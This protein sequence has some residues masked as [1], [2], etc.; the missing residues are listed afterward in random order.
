PA[1]PPPSSSPVTFTTQPT[2][3][4]VQTIILWDSA[5][6]IHTYAEY[7]SYDLPGELSVL[8]S[9][10]SVHGKVVDLNDYD[11]ITPPYAQW[12]AT[13]APL[14]NALAANNV[15]ADIRALLYSFKPAYPNLKYLVLVG[16][17]HIIPFRRVDDLNPFANEA[18]YPT[19]ARV[20]DPATR[21]A[22]GSQ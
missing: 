1:V 20:P 16:S 3:P 7:F 13:T 12:D 2:D 4:S 9:D 22:L 5:R 19:T 21:E 10:P 18:S 8:A 14:N 17:D 6:M 11:A 15:A